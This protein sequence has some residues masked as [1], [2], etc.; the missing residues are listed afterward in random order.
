MRQ[1]GLLK[2]KTKSYF[3]IKCITKPKVHE[4]HVAGQTTGR[5]SMTNSIFKDEISNSGAPRPQNHKKRMASKHSDTPAAFF[6]YSCL[7]ICCLPT[8]NTDFDMMPIP[9]L[10][11]GYKL[12]TTANNGSS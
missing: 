6:T 11:H 10:L 4:V 7:S 8:V 2:R 1:K 3:L 12:Q 5:K 9:L